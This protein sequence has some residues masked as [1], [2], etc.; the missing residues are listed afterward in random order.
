MLAVVVAFGASAADTVNLTLMINHGADDAPLF[1]TVANNFTAKHP[2]IKIDVVNV[3][4]GNQYYDKLATQ[5][6]SD[7]VPD[8]FYMRGGSGDAKYYDKGIAHPL[9]DVIKRDAAEVNVPDFIQSQ[10]A[11]L[12]YKGSWRALPYDYSVIGLF[13]NKKLFDA[14][15]VKYPTDDWTWDDLLKAA[16]KLTKKS[17]SGVVTQY[18]L[19]T[20][21]F[22]F[23][24]NFALGNIWT[25]GG[26]MLTNDN[27]GVLLDSPE[28][29]KAVTYLAEFVTKYGVAPGPGTVNDQNPFFTGQAA[30]CFDGSW[31]TMQYRSNCSFPFD[32]AMM[33]KNPTTGKR[34]V[35]ATGG[36]FAISNHTKHFE[37]AWQFLKY[38]TGPEAETILIATPIRS[39]P[40]RISIQKVWAANISKGGLAPK[41]VEAFA[42]EEQ[43]SAR[44]C[45]PVY[46]DWT[47][48]VSNIFPTLTDSKTN[49]PQALK[50]CANQIR[51]A[52]GAVGLKVT[53]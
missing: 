52:I 5:M 46:F 10:I 22:A 33:P 3:A 15:G 27:S 4:S 28:T 35:A 12:Q 16:Q 2:N 30:M 29:I 31:A 40:A 1:T 47:T 23:A 43:L 39:V 51:D 6:V 49:I 9:D 17:S 32:V 24:T 34:V 38:L 13:Y 41:N 36:S 45:P 50:D 37:E 18:G 14:A 7:T 53:K 8:L 20:S 25:M 19:A 11:E 21:P 42:K 44:N 48:S 26:E